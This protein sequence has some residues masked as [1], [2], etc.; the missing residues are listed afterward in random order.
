MEPE[1]MLKLFNSLTRKK[2]EFVPIQPG[3][4]RMYVCGMTVYDLCHLG[5]ARV[6]VVFDVIVRHLRSLGY[7]VT[8]VRNITD[9]DDKII[10]RAHENGEDITALTGRFITAMNEDAEALGVLPPDLEPRATESMDTIIDMI[11]RL[12]D[13]GYAYQGENGDVFYAVGKFDG[14]GQ[15]SGKRVEELRVG[16]RVDV[17]QAKR[18]P[19]DFVLWKSAKPGEPGWPSPWGEG[20]PG[21][22]IECSAMSTDCLGNHFD[23]HGGGMDLQ[24]PHHENEIAQSEASTGEHFVNYWIHNGFVQVDEEKMSK[25]LGNFFTV[26]EI[27]QRYRAEEIRYFI[28]SSHYRSPLN[29]SDDNLDKARAALQRLYTALRDLGVDDSAGVDADYEQRFQAAMN[30]DFNTPEALA[31]LFDLARALNRSREHDSTDVARLANTLLQLAGRLGILQ[32]DPASY[33]HG[34]QEA[35]AQGPDDAAIE[36]LIARREQA[37][38]DRDWAE[39][40][41]IRDELTGLGI[42]LEDGGGGTRWRRE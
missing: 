5:H 42:V 15:L 30:D 31:V 28:L 25:S 13:K 12:V 6:L 33:L 8:Y 32:A 19:L 23:I 39:A 14:Y 40:D 38:A 4:V 10:A 17:E 21:W 34:Q 41:R 18:D 22:H 24:F 27:L 26:R 20:R 1:P 35:G 29:Y 36:A 3:K 9:I 16:A 7:D 11:G 2:E 37:R